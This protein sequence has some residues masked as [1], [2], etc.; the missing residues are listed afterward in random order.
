M[1]KTSEI[2]KSVNFKKCMMLHTVR[3]PHKT[4]APYLL[5][6]VHYYTQQMRSQLL[7]AVE[8]LQCDNAI[9][10]NQSSI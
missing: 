8:D 4:K 1:K 6:L 7:A 9:I 5:V 10:R 3:N 2:S